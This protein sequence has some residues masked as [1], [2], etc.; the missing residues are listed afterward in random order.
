[1]LGCGKNVNYLSDVARMR[2][3]LNHFFAIAKIKE[4]QISSDVRGSRKPLSAIAILRE[5]K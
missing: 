2:G 4:K 1:L 5:S 3:Y